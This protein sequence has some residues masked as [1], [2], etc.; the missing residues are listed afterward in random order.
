MAVLDNEEEQQQEGV[1]EEEQEED[2]AD[3]VMRHAKYL[4]IDPEIDAAFMWIAEEALDADVPE[5]W[6]TGEGEGEYAGL[7]YYYN[8]ATGESSWDHPLDEYY[9]QKFKRK[10]ARADKEEDESHENRRSKAR[11]RDSSRQKHSDT[12]KGDRSRAG[13]DESSEQ[14]SSRRRRD[15]SRPS[16]RGHGKSSHRHKNDGERTGADGSEAEHGRRRSKRSQGREERSRDEEGSRGRH[17]NGGRDEP[18]RSSAHEGRSGSDPAQSP[19]EGGNHSTRVA[20]DDDSEMGLDGWVSVSPGRRKSSSSSRGQAKS[21]AA[22]APKGKGK[23]D[24]DVAGEYSSDG[25]NNLSQRGEGGGR[26]GRGRVTEQQPQEDLIATREGIDMSPNPRGDGGRERETHGQKGLLTASGRL[27]TVRGKREHKHKSLD[28]GRGA[29]RNISVQPS[30]RSWNNNDLEEMDFEDELLA[31]EGGGAEEQS[32]SGATPG[33]INDHEP[34]AEAPKNHVGRAGVDEGKRQSCPRESRGRKTLHQAEAREK[35]N[36]REETLDDD[37][38]RGAMPTSLMVTIDGDSNDWPGVVEN[39]TSSLLLEQSRG[40]SERGRSSEAHHAKRDSLELEQEVRE[41]AIQPGAASP[42]A[43][44]PATSKDSI[45]GD[46]WRNARQ[47]RGGSA[48]GVRSSEW[49]DVPRSNAQEQR[50]VVGGHGDWNNYYQGRL[51]R[52]GLTDDRQAGRAVGDRVEVEMIER[53]RQQHEQLQEAVSR[54]SELETKVVRLET[55]LDSSTAREDHLR[56]ELAAAARREGTIQERLTRVAA[57]MASVELANKEK[58]ETVRQELKGVREQL[59]ATQASLARKENEQAAV[60]EGQND[61]PGLRQ[62]LASREAEIERQRKELTAVQARLTDATNQASESSREVHRATDLAERLRLEAAE[63]RQILA[64]SE[65]SSLNHALSRAREEVASKESE[66]AKV[67]EETKRLRMQLGQEKQKVADAENRL[68]RAKASFESEAESLRARTAELLSA[69]TS[70][71]REMRNGQQDA[72]A[73]LRESERGRDAALYEAK[74]STEQA[75]SAETWRLRETRRAEVAEAK[76]L[77]TGT[78]VAELRSEAAR[79]RA[80]TD[81]VVAPHLKKNAEL[82]AQLEEAR[83]EVT[84]L[85]AEGKR[86]QG[87]HATEMA[88][89]KGEV[90]RKLPWIAEKAV[91]EA[92]KQWRRRAEEETTAVRAERDRRLKELQAAMTEG[93]ARRQ[94]DVAR[95]RAEAERYR[96]VAERLAAENRSIRGELEQCLVADSSLSNPRRARGSLA[97][98]RNVAGS[99]GSPSTV[100]DRILTGNNGASGDRTEPVRRGGWEGDLEAQILGRVEAHINALRAQL[101]HKTTGLTPL[102]GGDG[103]IHG[104]E[105]GGNLPSADAPRAFEDPVGVMETNTSGGD[106]HAPAVDGI[107]GKIG[108]VAPLPIQTRGKYHMS[109]TPAERSGNK[110]GLT[111]VEEMR[112]NRLLRASSASASTPPPS[113]ATGT[114]GPNARGCT[115]NANSGLRAMVEGDP[116]TS[117]NLSGDVFGGIRDASRELFGVSPTGEARSFGNGSFGASCRIASCREE[118][119]DDLEDIS[120]GGFHA[121]CWKRKYVRGDMR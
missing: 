21:I 15:D 57:E 102:N 17:R 88:S 16:S 28:A 62:T 41:R 107:E 63:N 58:E 83:R 81:E 72:L 42:G 79:L 52:E 119:E 61:I 56:E 109:P 32:L 68:L 86:Q 114:P 38:T 71:E 12:V 93:E 26:N 39:Q 18:R 77:T 2:Y 33:K 49:E 46:G 90:S 67:A 75:A 10:K 54:T 103:A 120:D 20:T 112:L 69:N 87:A 44:D 19:K 3:A 64:A 8:E 1:E 84:A 50:G 13:G 85:T 73:R 27:E 96:A 45:R 91:S 92:G 9:R 4:G 118:Q 25:A 94:D 116:E 80:S 117:F 70:I 99:A 40:K 29:D 78:E 60:V 30:T 121:G 22:G 7:V 5:G 65:M 36:Y 95:A 55:N 59:E 89:L 31:F 100:V 24:K 74:R 98:R 115:L 104:D 101:N 82:Q 105:V 48:T 76:A 14:S 111:E 35:G 23:R 37:S 47:A 51:A 53:Q 6:I 34:L 97:S 11:G 110:D 66:A 108:G 106:T 43:M 113:G